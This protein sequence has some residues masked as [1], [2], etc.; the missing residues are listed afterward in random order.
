[1]SF[2]LAGRPG[3]KGAVAVNQRD[4][5]ELQ[6]ATGAIRAG[7]TI[8]TRQ[9]GLQSSDLKRVLIAGGFGSF[10]RRSN[11][12]RIGLLPV[13]IDRRR[14]QY[15]GN[16]SLNGAKYALVSTKARDQAERLAR[17]T[18]HVQL[19]EDPDFQDLFAESMIFP[20]H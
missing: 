11:A 13:D 16:A 6:L 4:V 9:V 14:I 19:S 7:V 12:Q 1:M 3:T 5:R 17:Q 8:L 15:V 18:T 2:L 20:E 10:I